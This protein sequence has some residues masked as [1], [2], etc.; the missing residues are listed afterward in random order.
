MSMPNIDV[1]MKSKKKV[2]TPNNFY[3]E[4][5]TP[6][7]TV[8]AQ[9]NVELFKGAFDYLLKNTN[10]NENLNDLINM[11]SNNEIKAI[12]YNGMNKQKIKF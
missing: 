1:N 3:I 11:T 7:Q 4:E 9:N 6:I 2:L 10:F 5:K 12:I 8:I